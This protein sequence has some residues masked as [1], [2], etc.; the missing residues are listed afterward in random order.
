MKPLSEQLSEMSAH[1]KQVEDAAAVARKTAA[2]KLDQA[3]EDSHR[4]A[5]AALEKVKRDV[6]QAHGDMTD[7]NA[8]M[9]EKVDR[10]IAAL[11]AHMAQRKHEFD[12]KRADF[13]ADRLDE[14]AS[15]AI[16]YAIASIENARHAVI[17]AITGRIK[18]EK[19][20][21]S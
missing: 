4:A 19:T 17:D 10:D 13:N 15:F 3:W 9:K 18:A 20:K 2:D 8:S 11:N 12:T 5:T 7:F 6:A 16:D 1:A 14:Q 21:L